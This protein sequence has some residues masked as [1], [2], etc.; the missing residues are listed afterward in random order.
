MASFRAHD[1]LLYVATPTE[2][3]K[4][5]SAMVNAH[6]SQMLWYRWLWISFSR[7]MIINDLRLLGT[8]RF[9]EQSA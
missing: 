5:Q 9:V 8:E 1:N 4:I 7:Y 3:L 2:S 6:K